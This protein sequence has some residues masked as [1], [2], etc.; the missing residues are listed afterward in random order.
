MTTTVT[1]SG[2][3]FPSGA[4]ENHHNVFSLFLACSSLLQIA[5]AKPFGTINGLG[6]HN[7]HEMVTRLAFQ[8]PTGQK[9][10]G[11]CF[12]PI[13]LDNLAG[14]HVGSIPGLGD[15]GMVGSPDDLLPE[16]PEAHCDDADYFPASG[17]PRS[18]AQATEQ[19]QRCVD[20]LR[21]RFGQGVRGT[22]R[23][24]DNSDRIIA[25]MAE[26]ESDEC[27]HDHR[28]TYIQRPEMD[29]VYLTVI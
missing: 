27:D 8:C 7:E 12:E 17:Y 19:L 4:R 10:N 5:N 26:L 22:A 16:G 1:L 15:N 6:Q 13:T 24:L 25:G 20:H 9:S 23:M 11:V 3:F 21:M 2:A 29:C 18:R 14:T 28:G